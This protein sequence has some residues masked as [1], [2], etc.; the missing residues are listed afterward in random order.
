M[1]KWVDTPSLGFNGFVQSRLQG[2]SEGQAIRE[3]V[4]IDFYDNLYYVLFTW[5]AP[6]TVR[7]E[8][9]S[10][11]TFCSLDEAKAYSVAVLTLT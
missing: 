5:Q 9:N 3:L 8:H 4:E 2:Q 10:S 6:H 7:W 11:K 1:L